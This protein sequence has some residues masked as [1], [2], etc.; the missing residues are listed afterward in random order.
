[1]LVSMTDFKINI[2]ISP[3]ELPAF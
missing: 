1:M 2:F 3:L